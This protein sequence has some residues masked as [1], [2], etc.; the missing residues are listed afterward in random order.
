MRRHDSGVNPVAAVRSRLADPTWRY[1][2]LCGIPAAVVVTA[3]AWPIGSEM[4]FTPVFVAAVVAGFLFPG[5]REQVKALGVRVTLVG[6]LP[7]LAVLASSVPHAV[8]IPNPPWF[9][10]LILCLV[11][12]GILFFVVVSAVMDMAGAL[13]GYWLAGKAGRYRAV[14]A[15]G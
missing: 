9:T 2:L 13:L 6:M 8:Q 15:S 7:G 14:T 12:A 4:D 11:A 1:A 3:N 10:V 5:E